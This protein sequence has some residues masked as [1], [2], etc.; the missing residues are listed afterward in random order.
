MRFSHI[1]LFICSLIFLLSC[2]N[3]EP[4]HA[5]PEPCITPSSISMT[6]GDEAVATVENL[7]DFSVTFDRTIIDVTI[8]NP[9]ILIKAIAPGTSVIN[10]I[11][12]TSR[13]HCD[14]TVTDP[15]DVDYDFAPEAANPDERYVSRSLS[16]YYSTPGTIFAHEPNGTIHII[17]IATGDKILFNPKAKTLSENGTDVTLSD[18]ILE[19]TV[20]AKRWFHLIDSNGFHIVL[21]IDN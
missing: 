4:S 7:T 8:V 2:G 21:V 15:H 16:L 3:D 10:I 14:V 6:V 18:V 19:K 9:T 12:S 20:G 11:G 1:S 13:L 17:N 5:D